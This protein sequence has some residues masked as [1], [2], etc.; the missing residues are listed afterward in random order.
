M[1]VR[2]PAYAYF[3]FDTLSRV[4]YSK[5][6]MWSLCNGAWAFCY[7]Q[8]Y[9]AFWTTV[10]GL[11]LRLKGRYPYRQILLSKNLSKFGIVLS[12]LLPR[13]EPC[14]ELTLNLQLGRPHRPFTSLQPLHHTFVED[15]YFPQFSPFPC[16]TELK[17]NNYA[18]HIRLRRHD[19]RKRH[20][21]NL[22]PG[23]PRL[24]SRF[25]RQGPI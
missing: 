22:C 20:H 17:L 21:L 7:S 1:F 15:I 16:F 9:S 24:P 8:L 18:S 19:N 10:S 12:F 25:P 14:G 4:I 5:S 13:P 23:S 6:N 2:H 11:L 3:A